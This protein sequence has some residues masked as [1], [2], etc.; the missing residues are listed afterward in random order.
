MRDP[1]LAAL[2]SILVRYSTRVSKGDVCVIQSTTSAEPLVQAVYEEV[3]RAEGLPIM[4]LSTQGAAA[5]FYGLA[6]DD[7][8]E[9]I[10]QTATW[11]AENADVRIA[12]MA[13][14]NTRELSRTDP[15]EGAV[16]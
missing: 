14:V 6:T 16:I 4:Q 12:I 11:A 1:R 9:W 3:L 10:P 13:D 8:L 5:S 2:A 7:Q 15:T